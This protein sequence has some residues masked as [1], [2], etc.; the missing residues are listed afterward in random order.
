VGWID[1]SSTR[2]MRKLFFIAPYHIDIDYNKKKA[3]IT[4]L[5]LS[6]NFKLQIAEDTKTGNSLSA[7][8]TVILL[9][10]CCFAI[11][12][13]SY[14]RPSCYYEVGYLQGQNK[15]VYLICTSDTTIHQLLNK[16]NLLKY[17]NID[18]YKLI[19]ESI[20]MQESKTEGNA[21]K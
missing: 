2:K 15:N 7:K 10:E 19:I 5:C 8:D 12:D 20:L 6:F 21:T 4:E 11:A 16:E 3:I 18:S 9:N 14:E 13:L 17:S 1:T